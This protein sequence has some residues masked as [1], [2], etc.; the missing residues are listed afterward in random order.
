MLSLFDGFSLLLSSVCNRKLLGAL[1]IATRSKNATSGSWP[2][3]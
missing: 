1:G 3:Y 2:Y